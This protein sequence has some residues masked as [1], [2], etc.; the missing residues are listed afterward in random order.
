[1]GTL[2]ARHYS[3]RR[4]ENTYAIKMILSQSVRTRQINEVVKMLWILVG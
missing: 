2:D 4:H 3:L 1:M